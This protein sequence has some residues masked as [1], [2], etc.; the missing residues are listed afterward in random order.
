MGPVREPDRRDDGVVP[1]PAC[2]DRAGPPCEFPN[3]GHR[4]HGE[5]AAPCVIIRSA[6]CSARDRRG[7]DH[8]THKRGGSEQQDQHQE[9]LQEAVPKDQAVVLW[10]GQYRAACIR[11]DIRLGGGTIENMN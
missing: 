10:D 6:Q 9:A 2:A 3:D 7:P 11:R 4:T 8:P 1:G 5:L